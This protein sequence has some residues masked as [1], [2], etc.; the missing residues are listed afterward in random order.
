MVNLLFLMAEIKT[1]HENTKQE[2]HEIINQKSFVI[3][4]SKGDNH[5]Y[6]LYDKRFSVCNSSNY[7]NYYI[8]HSP[9]KAI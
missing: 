7:F 6:Y 3:F 1:N 4:S 2:K 8:F 5:D 9:D